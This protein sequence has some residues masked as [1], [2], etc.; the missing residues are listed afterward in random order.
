MHG[1]LVVL[2]C[3]KVQLM[4]ELFYFEQVGVAWDGVKLQCHRGTLCCD[5][6]VLYS[7]AEGG[8]VWLHGSWLH[9][10]YGSQH[11]AWT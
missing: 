3:L 11:D 5:V 1:L 4:Y 8:V 6:T 10:Q 9:S 2:T 7:C